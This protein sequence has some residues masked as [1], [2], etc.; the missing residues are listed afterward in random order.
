[1]ANPNRPLA[2]KRIVVTRAADQ[3]RDLG[4]ALESKDADVIL[5]PLVAFAPPDDW[6]LLDEQLQ[7]LN[8]FDAI[9]FL[10]RNAVRYLFQRCRE[11]GVKCEFSPPRRPFIATVGEGTRDAA[12]R[13]GLIVDYVS[14]AH[15]AESLVRE[16]R[17]SLA[18]RNVFLPR[19]DRGDDE[20]PRKLR[21]AGARVT[22]V[23]AYRT[24]PPPNIDPAV[25]NDLREG[26]VDS[27]VFASPS[28]FHN[29]CD[30]I[31][32]AEIAE[33]AQR[34]EFAAIGPTTARAIRDSGVRVALEAAAPSASAMA[35]A[36]VEHFASRDVKARPS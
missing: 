14:K 35:D 3:S 25:L 10:S 33:I 9:L 15:T 20:L 17:S 6:R 24:I 34:V 31:P 16:L 12:I 28:A 23:V 18:G 11:V 19:G 29:L 5:L 22:Q 4:S 30:L 27:V 7:K 1:M 32:P 2:G 26:A 13:E 36:L 8:G 21:D